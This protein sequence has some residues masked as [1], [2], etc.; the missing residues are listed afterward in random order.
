VERVADYVAVLDYSV[1][2][3]CCSSDTFRERVR[4]LVARF[5][6]EPPRELPPIPGLLRATRSENEL[7]LIVA[8]LNGRTEHDLESLGAI[9]VDEQP[10]SL[11]D[12]LIAHVGRQGDKSFMLR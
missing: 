1:L 7:S 5:P 8:N 2:R 10:L 11:E 12:A 6:G 3:V 9:A 4:R